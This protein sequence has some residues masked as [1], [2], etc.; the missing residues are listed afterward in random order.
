MLLSFAAH[1]GCVDTPLTQMRKIVLNSVGEQIEY[2]LAATCC[3]LDSND[4]AILVER[5]T[6][7]LS[8][9]CSDTGETEP[10]Y[11][12]SS[13]TSP[14]LSR[15]T[16]RQTTLG[17]S[18]FVHGSHADETAGRYADVDIVAILWDDAFDNLASLR[19]ALAAIREVMRASLRIDP[20]QHHVP[21]IIV[22]ADVLVPTANWL[23][24]PPLFCE[25]LALVGG[26]TPRPVGPIVAPSRAALEAQLRATSTMLMSLSQFNPCFA[27]NAKALISTILLLPAV[28][29]Q[30]DGHLLS[31]RDS[32]DAYTGELSKY[33][34]IASRIR[35]EWSYTGHDLAKAVRR[36]LSFRRGAG[37]LRR[38]PIVQL[39]PRLHKAILDLREQIPNIARLARLEGSKH[40]SSFTS[41]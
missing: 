9:R 12:Y 1:A 34:D 15:L 8:H 36:T 41:E 31:K 17:V 27:Y 38:L 22:A 28:I 5:V 39:D 19:L 40:L 24:F 10:F 14:V 4:D 3:H 2:A 30:C 18:L 23:I 33:I 26:V 13:N 7:M 16:S 25:R 11:W 21:K 6:F 35:A 37:A 32:F 20:L 29:L